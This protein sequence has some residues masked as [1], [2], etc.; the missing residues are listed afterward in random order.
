MAILKKL[1]KQKI[2]PKVSR[3]VRIARW[4]AKVQH[5]YPRLRRIYSK[6]RRKARKFS[7]KSRLR[8]PRRKTAISKG[9]LNLISDARIAAIHK[10]R[11]L[12][13]KGKIAFFAAVPAHYLYRRRASARKLV[14]RKAARRTSRR[15]FRAYRRVVSSSHRITL[16]IR[17]RLLRRRRRAL[18]LRRKRNKKRR[19]SL[20]SA[21]RGVRYLRGAFR[22]KS[23][24]TYRPYVPTH[25]LRICRTRGFVGYHQLYRARP[26]LKQLFFPL[27]SASSKLKIR[28]NK[29]E[30]TSL[31]RRNVVKIKPKKIKISFGGRRVISR[32]FRRTKK[33]KK[34]KSVSYTPARRHP[35]H[36]IRVPGKSKTKKSRKSRLPVW[37]L[38]KRLRL[39]LVFKRATKR[40]IRCR[41]HTVRHKYYSVRCRRRTR[42]KAK[43][44][45]KIRIKRR[46]KIRRRFKK[47]P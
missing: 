33:S 37:R 40:A 38:T 8:V 26:L 14:V 30:T 24:S 19:L 17:R 13:K 41:R 22:R 9:R 4:R 21:V 11:K 3:K 6:A 46:R 39:W 29:G 44:R 15:R 36:P 10:L 32:L 20:C 2:R 47:R 12:R 31:R 45:L 18:L 16:R 7:M 25:L 28:N 27:P 23:I 5:L 35:T 1:K 42:V 34:V 43:R